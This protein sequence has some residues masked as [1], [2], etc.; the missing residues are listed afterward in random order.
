MFFYF[1]IIHT[2]K[3]LLA[4]PAA[5]FYNQLKALI[6]GGRATPTD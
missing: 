2:I 5:V 6:V 4:L 1:N 3:K